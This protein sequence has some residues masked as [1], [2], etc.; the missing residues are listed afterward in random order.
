M[1]VLVRN[2]CRLFV[3]ELVFIFLLI[4]SGELCSAMTDET[5]MPLIP[6]IENLYN[7]SFSKNSNINYLNSDLVFNTSIFNTNIMLN[8]RFQST[9][10][11]SNNYD[12]RDANDFSLLLSRPISSNFDLILQNR[13]IYNSDSKSLNTNKIIDIS[14]IPIISY[15]ISENIS[16][17]L[18]L[19]AE[20]NKR[21]NI[22]S[23]ATALQFN[24]N[25]HQ[26]T[27]DEYVFDSELYYKKALYNNNRGNQT[28]NVNTLIS[29]NYSNQDKIEF[30]MNYNLNEKDFFNFINNSNSDY[31]L[32]RNSDQNYSANFKIIYSP[33][34]HYNL[35][36]NFE[37]NTQF[38][39][40]YFNDFTESIPNSMFRRNSHI[41]KILLTNSLLLKFQKF[42][43]IL[44]FDYEANEESFNSQALNQKVSASVLAS[45][46]NIQKMNDYN[47]SR[48][49]IAFNSS[50]A[51]SRKDSLSTNLVASLFRYN[52]P[53]KENIDEHDV[54]YSAIYAVY[55]HYFNRTFSVFIT[56]E[57]KSQH[58]VY[59]NSENSA[60]S[61]QLKS[62]K[63]KPELLYSNKFLFYN[64]KIEILANYHIYD[65]QARV[66]TL[67]TYSYRQISYLDSAS[68]SLN[69]NWS[70]SSNILCRY[71]IRSTLNWG[72][73]AENPIKGNLEQIYRLMI[74]NKIDI[75]SFGLGLGFYKV[76]QVDLIKQNW[77]NI[78]TILSPEVIIGIKF[79][80]RGALL[81]FGK[82]DFQNTNSYKRQVANI[83]MQTTYAF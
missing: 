25:I 38:K 78:S 2:S 31:L 26:L 72:Y 46:Q 33:T 41:T 83:S 36:S 54:S 62:I 60:Q 22:I 27:Y 45:Y 32:E 81:F 15:K 57:L 76:E 69:D 48:I 14:S 65:F 79:S 56:G 74:N 44:S 18:G 8:N 29:A 5:T 51:I 6:K 66:N 37:Y 64:P 55:K 71:S 68:L 67:N 50:I 61:N 23:N 39:D 17:A 49:R 30:G 70:L 28:I 73:F 42:S 20:H 11:N 77:T 59:I 3:I 75:Y 82:Y 16:T 12:C 4:G 53:H 21:A 80:K 47:S 40:R 43:S 13:I 63:L 7:I 52:T 35:N 1:I 24:A 58:Y 19:G 34:S 9:V 10:I